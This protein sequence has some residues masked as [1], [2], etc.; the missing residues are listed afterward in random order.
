MAL[1]MPGITLGFGLWSGL[2]WPF[3]AV[4]LLA[5]LAVTAYIALGVIAGMADDP[6]LLV[7]NETRMTWLAFP[8]LMAF[9]IGQGV[10]A[11][12]NAKGG[13]GME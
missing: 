12:I 3:A 1:Y 7:E 8:S 13:G 9:L 5:A 10:G 4:R 11:V 6:A 2:R